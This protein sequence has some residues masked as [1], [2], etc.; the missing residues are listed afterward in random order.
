MKFP[1][2]ANLKVAI[3]TNTGILAFERTS[4]F[5]EIF[6]QARITVSK[7]VMFDELADSKAMSSSGYIEE[8]KNNARSKGNSLQW[9]S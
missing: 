7:K 3:V 4:A 2:V 1:K 8:V 9:H 5:E 6:H